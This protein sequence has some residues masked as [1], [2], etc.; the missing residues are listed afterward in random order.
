MHTPP[1]PKLS[2]SRGRYRSRFSSWA[3]LRLR[4][5]QRSARRRFSLFSALL[6]ACPFCC[7]FCVCASFLR[8]CFRSIRSPYQ[9]SCRIGW[10]AITLRSAVQ[11]LVTLCAVN[12]DRRACATLYLNLKNCKRRKP[13]QQ[14]KTRL[15]IFV[16]FVV[17]GVYLCLLSM[18]LPKPKGKQNFAF[19]LK[20]SKKNQQRIS[21]RNCSKNC[22]C[23]VVWK[24]KI[25]GSVMIV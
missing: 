11:F 20:I 14:K 4:R 16:D 10:V 24:V 22:V 1:L 2:R 5:G 3:A 23:F 25:R 12:F 18:F 15:A 13:R 8:F 7:L 9:R 19:L 17:A 21:N 6:F